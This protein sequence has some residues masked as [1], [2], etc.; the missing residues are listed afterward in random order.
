MLTI[1]VCVIHVSSYHTYNVV[2]GNYLLNDIL[3]WFGGCIQTAV[4]NGTSY[5]AV[6]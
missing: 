2:K 6:I 5:L 4:A 3:K 1:H